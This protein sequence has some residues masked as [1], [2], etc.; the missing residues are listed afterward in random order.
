MLKIL[1]TEPLL[2]FLPEL[3]HTLVI[4]SCIPKSYRDHFLYHIAKIKKTKN[5]V[6]INPT[7]YR[8]YIKFY[9]IP[10]N[11]FKKKVKIK[12]K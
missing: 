10:I 11:L 7:K 12:Q 5:A 9:R 2:I 4:F 6:C 3:F 8:I 1:K